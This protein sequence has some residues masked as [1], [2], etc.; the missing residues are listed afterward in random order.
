MAHAFYTE[1]PEIQTSALFEWAV[2]FQQ[3]FS[4]GVPIF[5]VLSGFLITYLMLREQEGLGKFNVLNFYIRR[6]LR[7]WPLYFLVLLIGF[8]AFP[9]IRDWVLQEPIVET[10]N[11]LMY[12]LFLSNFDQINTGV[13][14]YGVGLGPTWSVSIEEQY[15]LL[16]PLLLVL[17]PRRRFVLAIAAVVFLSI[18]LTLQFGLNNKHTIYCMIYLG[19]GSLFGYLAFY[20]ERFISKITSIPSIVFLFILLL[21]FA[22]L[23]SNIFYV[24]SFWM[25]LV[26]A[27]AIGYIIT[28]QCFSARFEFRK[29]PFV[30]RIGKYTYGLYLYHVICNFIIYTI[31]TK[32][33]KTEESELLAV[34][35]RPTLS[36]AISIWMSYFSYHYFESYFLRLK[37]KFSRS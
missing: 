32:I 10:A 13:L 28:F 30:E 8:V 16:W 26:I 33:M 11:P 20:H 12:A 37:Q 15:Y 1:S 21:F 36:L 25:I 29:I 22:L 4:F 9:L 24:H 2:H 5:F 23:Y 35:V 34:F 19:I 3:V 14:P 18:V 17:L 31:F 27:L 7:I 6:V